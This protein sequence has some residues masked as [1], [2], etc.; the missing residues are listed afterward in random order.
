MTEY[1][2]PQT[3]LEFKLQIKPADVRYPMGDVRRYTSVDEAYRF[4]AE[5]GETIYRR[6]GM[7]RKDQ[8][9]ADRLVEREILRKHSALGFRTADMQDWI[10]SADKVVRDWRVAGACMEKMLSSDICHRIGADRWNVD[11]DYG[12]LQDPRAICEAFCEVHDE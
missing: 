8:Q 3:L 1:A 5:S 11:D 7:S 9:L 12:W 4:G 10:S 2:W 6:S